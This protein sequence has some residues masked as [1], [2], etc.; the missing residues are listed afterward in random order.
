MKIC[1]DNLEGIHLTRNGYFLKGTVTYI[2]KESC[3]KCRNPYL[4]EKRR[5][6]KFCS[7]SCARSGKNHPMY[8]RKHTVGSRKKMSENIPDYRGPL[9][10][11]YKGDKAGLAV[12]TTCKDRLEFYE[13]VRQQVNTKR[14]EVRCAYCGRW[15]VPTVI[16]VDSRFAAINN[17]NHGECRLYCSE[18]CK[19]VCPTYGQKMYPKG[20]KH[21]TSREVSSYLRKMVLKRDNWTCQI[22]GKTILEIQL[23]VHHMDPVA[24]NPMFQNDMDSCITLCKKCHGMVH[25]QHGCRYVDLRCKKEN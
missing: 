6:S 3:E 20:F 23:H 21:T 24:Q 1:W 15:F 5:N 7:F 8:G 9:N 19:L 17:L 14:L 16:A 13:D 18:N 25:K 22:C 12:Y 2:Y 4:A 11:N 10:P